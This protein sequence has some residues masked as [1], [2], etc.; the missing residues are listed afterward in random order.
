MTES[1][2]LSAG[3]RLL[4]V[5]ALTGFVQARTPRDSAAFDHWR[6][7]HNGG[8]AGGVQLLAL[9]VLGACVAAPAYLALPLLLV[10]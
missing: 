2:L 10:L 3:L 1:L 4:G 7:V 6:V 9:N 8:T 5:A